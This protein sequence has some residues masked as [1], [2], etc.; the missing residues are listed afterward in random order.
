MSRLL[1]KKLYHSIIK[2]IL[3]FVTF[4]KIRHRLKEN[5]RIKSDASKINR[6]VRVLNKKSKKNKKPVV[7]YV[8]HFDYYSPLQQRPNHMFN[9]LADKGFPCLFCSWQYS[10][11]RKNLYVIPTTWLK[12]ILY[13]KFPK[14]FDVAYSYP[15]WD[16]PDFFKYINDES[17]VIY[18]LI[19]DF[20]L[21]E[22]PAVI[23]QAKNMF[24]KLI[25]RDNTFVL[26]SANKL[27]KIAENMGAPKANLVLNQNAVNIDDFTKDNLPIPD[28]MKK[29]LKKKKTIIGY[30]GALTDSWFDFKLI[31]DLVKKCPQ[32]EFVLM[33]LKYKDDAIDKTEEYINYL[34]KFDNFTYIPP[35]PYKEIPAYAKCW[36]VATIPFKINDITLGCSPVK[37]FEYM[38]MGLPIVTTPMPECELY[39]SVFIAKDSAEF[40]KQIKNALRAK[41]TK[42]YQETLAREAS[43]NTWESRVNDMIEIIEKNYK[44]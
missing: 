17:L 37:L 5:N 9:I 25:K 18:E 4:S 8:S 24:T 2:P 16:M 7:V 23:K 13:K 6:L 14:V 38:A 3:N 29:I 10:K 44:E 35:V 15:Y 39:K 31:K 21:L 1:H 20:D 40:E 26:A 41:E 27:Y 34:S 30:Y 43:E 32:Y 19:D 36:D 28:V 33:G 12:Y 11:P 42:N 22:N